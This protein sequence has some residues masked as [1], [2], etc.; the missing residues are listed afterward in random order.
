MGKR[1]QQPCLNFSGK[2]CLTI[3]WIFQTQRGILVNSVTLFAF[4]TCL[5][6]IN[7]L[8]LGD[9]TKVI[10][11]VMMFRV[12]DLLFCVFIQCCS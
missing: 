1:M 6:S 9:Q 7:N 12:F 8:N 10:N 4:K 5:N 11:M 3:H 2:P